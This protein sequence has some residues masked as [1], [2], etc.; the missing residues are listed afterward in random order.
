MSPYEL[1]PFATKSDSLE[2]KGRYR[3]DFSDTESE[4]DFDSAASVSDYDGPDP[5]IDSAHNSMRATLSAQTAAESIQDGN[6]PR[7]EVS[8]NST[9]AT[10]NPLWGNEFPKLTKL[11]SSKRRPSSR[12]S[13]LSTRPNP[14]HHQLLGS[15]YN[16]Y[17]KADPHLSLE[18]ISG[19]ASD[20]SL[21]PPSQRKTMQAASSRRSRRHSVSRMTRYTHPLPTNDRPL[22][23][24]MTAM[25]ANSS[26]RRGKLDFAGNGTPIPNTPNSKWK[27]IMTPTR[28]DNFKYPES[29]EQYY[30]PPQ[31]HF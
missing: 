29:P 4:T 15:H 1:L 23:P 13:T 24:P 30:D 19:V 5:P 28:Y 2:A 25:A 31:S 16:P 10:Q 3:Y 8:C 11:P 14:T 12:L 21:N 26:R 18:L 27:P 20:N 9:Q 6:E 17:L 7:N 22:S